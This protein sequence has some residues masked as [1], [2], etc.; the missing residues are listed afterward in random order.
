MKFKLHQQSVPGVQFW[1]SM[2]L[3]S[4]VEL[5]LLCPSHQFSKR[6]V[7]CES[8]KMEGIVLKFEALGCLGFFRFPNMKISTQM[9]PFIEREQAQEAE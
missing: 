9:W 1:Q 3:C 2:S 4:A 6:V 7:F 8:K 5:I